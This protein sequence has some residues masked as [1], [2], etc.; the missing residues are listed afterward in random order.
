MAVVMGGVLCYVA[1]MIGEWVGPAWP[2]AAL[3]K[4]C[5]LQCGQLVSLAHDVGEALTVHHCRCKGAEGKQE[6]YQG[7]LVG[8]LEPETSHNLRQLC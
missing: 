6:T 8:Q 3:R 4:G 7:R 5:A 2:E 1:G